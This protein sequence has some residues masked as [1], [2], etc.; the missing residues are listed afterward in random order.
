[1]IVT[2]ADLDRVTYLSFCTEP[3]VIRAIRNKG[4]SHQ[5]ISNQLPFTVSLVSYESYEEYSK[6]FDARLAM[7]KQRNSSR[8]TDEA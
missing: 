7:A 1:M 3:F 2:K 6:D 8:P 5:H 4:V